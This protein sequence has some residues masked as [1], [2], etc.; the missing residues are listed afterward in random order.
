MNE[1][2]M[3]QTNEVRDKQAHAETSIRTDRQR[4]PYNPQE[5]KDGRANT[6]VIAT[7]P[8]HPTRA[9]DWQLSSF[10]QFRG[11][12][13]VPAAYTVSRQAYLYQSSE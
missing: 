6:E 4:W 9:A 3:T 2:T 8:R 11:V 7:S 10:R 1:R 5:R 13:L 12:D